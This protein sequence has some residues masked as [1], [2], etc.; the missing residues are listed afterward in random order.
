M[1]LS[2]NKTAHFSLKVLDTSDGEVFRLLFIVNY[3]TDEGPWQERI[4]SRPF[5]VQSNRRKSNK[6]KSYEIC[7]FFAN[8]LVTAR[9]KPSVIGIKP[10]SGPSSEETEI[11]IK[12]TTYI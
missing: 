12:G 3:E 5:V 10:N 8:R 7:M 9:I 11:W 4:L 6:S 2:K 1:E